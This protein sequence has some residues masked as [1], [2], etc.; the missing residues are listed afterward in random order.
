MI[1]KVISCQELPDVFCAKCPSRKN[2]AMIP[3]MVAEDCSVKTV[4]TR[5]FR[6]R[7]KRRFCGFKSSRGSYFYSFFVCQM[8]G[9]HEHQPPASFSPLRV[10]KTP[11]FIL[12]GIYGSAKVNLPCSFPKK[13]LRRRKPSRVHVE[14]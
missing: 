1:Y 9:V 7:L 3:I 6:C 5:L 2:H 12:H 14:M 4:P 10:Q 13:T 8:G 11:I